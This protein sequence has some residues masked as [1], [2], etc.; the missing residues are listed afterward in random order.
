MRNW[1]S[2]SFHHSTSAHKGFYFTYEELKQAMIE[3]GVTPEQGFY[4]TYEELKQKLL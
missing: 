1:N 3:A 2:G 4:F